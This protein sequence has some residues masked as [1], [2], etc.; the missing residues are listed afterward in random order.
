MLPYDNQSGF[1]WNLTAQAKKALTSEARSR[2]EKSDPH[3][4][5]Q[6]LDNNQD[7]AEYWN[8]RG[9][10]E[11]Y[12]FGGRAGLQEMARALELA[13]QVVEN[14][15]AMGYINAQAG[16]RNQALENYNAAIGMDPN[17]YDGY[18][19]R[20]TILEHLGDFEGAIA[21]L[22]CALCLDHPLE[23]DYAHCFTINA[24]QRK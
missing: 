12:I 19:L 2:L 7:S 14:H 9:L 20:S 24:T 13:P 18:N 15:L 8:N 6:I 10:L 21:D 16:E 23:A 3:N 1:I 5:D 11:N 22:N 4:W 17:R